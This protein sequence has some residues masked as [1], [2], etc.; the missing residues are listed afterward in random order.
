MA[1]GYP[2]PLLLYA[3]A[4]AEEQCRRSGTQAARRGVG[5]AVPLLIARTR[6][7][8]IRGM[9]NGPRKRLCVCK[10]VYTV[11]NE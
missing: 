11:R 6:A 7:E 2:F 9:G 1:A 10:A 5:K 3:Q 4:R 8:E